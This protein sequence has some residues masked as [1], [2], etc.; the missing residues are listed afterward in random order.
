MRCGVYSTSY[1]FMHPTFLRIFRD[2]HA[3]PRTDGYASPGCPNVPHRTAGEHVWDSG[4][5]HVSM[6][7]I[8]LRR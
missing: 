5:I 7:L 1:S 2:S 4:T 6:F 3:P 8:T